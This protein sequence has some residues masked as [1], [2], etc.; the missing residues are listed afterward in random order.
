LIIYNKNP[1]VYDARAQHESWVI[2]EITSLVSLDNK[3]VI[4]AGSGS[5]K[6]AFQVA[7]I[8]KTVFA[9]EPVTNL[10]RFIQKKAAAEGI[11]NI[12]TI[13]GFLHAIPFPNHFVDVL[14][15]CRAI[16]WNLE[17][18]LK[19]VE[20]VVKPGGQIVH[21]PMYQNVDDPLYT[22][23]TSSK[24]KYKCSEFELGD[25]FTRKYWK[26]V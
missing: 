12:Y 13:D 18:E 3:V 8:A 26:Q 16:G 11:E 5:G 10:R 1:D 22:T 4:D 14:L 17:E 23:L 2:N 25:D 7:R 19:E 6:L 9:V 20:R 21:I 24:W 15:T